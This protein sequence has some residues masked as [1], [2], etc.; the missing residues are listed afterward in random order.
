MIAKEGPPADK[1][2]TLQSESQRIYQLLVDDPRL[3]TP[4]AVKALADN[5]HFVGDETQPFF[6]VPWKCAESQ[7]GLLGYVGL[8]ALAIAKERYGL[9][10]EVNVDV[11]DA[12]LTG[13]EAV[14][15]RHQG[16]WLSG[17]PKMMG[18]VQRWDH[19]KTRELYRQLA[20][21][22]YKTKDDRWFHLHGSMNPTPTLEMLNVPQHNEDNMTWPQIIEFYSDLVAKM[23]SK[24]LDDWS[25]NV[26]RVPGTICMELEEYEATA[27]VRLAKG[28]V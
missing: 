10:Q 14:F 22:I 3:N 25:N 16:E 13:L 5:V 7:A 26:Y 18:A 8:Y 6:P 23:D 24:T 15:V 19:G 21:N 9:E 20:T 1:A 17:N 2:Y 12:L 4:V 27:H 28:L 11:A